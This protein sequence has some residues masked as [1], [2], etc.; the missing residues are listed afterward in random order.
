MHGF[1]LET[2]SSEILTR[3]SCK[4]GALY[5]TQIRKYIVPNAESTDVAL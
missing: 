4:P 1:E 2:W 5:S 3:A